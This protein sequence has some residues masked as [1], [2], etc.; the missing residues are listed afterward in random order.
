MK[1]LLQQFPK[2]V[3]GLKIL[4]LIGLVGLYLH[5]ASLQNHLVNTDP[6]Q[7]DQLAYLRFAKTLRETNYNYL[8]PRNQMPV[9]PLIQSLIYRPGMTEEEFFVVGKDF[10]I[11]LSLLILAALYWL[12][13]KNFPPLMTLNMM[14]ITGF[15]VFMFKAPFFQAELIFYLLNLTGFLLLLRMCRKPTIQTGLITGLVF[16][17]AHMTK[18]SVIPGLALFLVVMA[19]QILFDFLFHRA[20]YHKLLRKKGVPIILLLV[21]FLVSVSGYIINSKQ[22]YGHYFYNVNSTFYIWY[23]S[24]SEAKAGT[25][26]NGDRLGWPDLPA[27]EIPSPSK[28]LQEHTLSQILKRLQDGLIRVISNSVL[29]YGYAIYLFVYS[30]LLFTFSLL[31][32]RLAIAKIRQHFWL[33]LFIAAYFIFYLLAVAWYTPIAKGNRFILAYF[34]PYMFVLFYV[35]RSTER[36]FGLQALKLLKIINLL[37]LCT[38]AG[39]IYYIMTKTIATFYGGL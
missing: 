19:A 39:H 35:L 20:T 30:I 25:I 8:M 3:Q 9:Y 37:V 18:A 22:V 14:L 24:W 34:L 28:Y 2:Q 13:K 38:L 23:D 10:N 17:I 31:N 36:Y 27:E 11:F 32:W 21:I 26:A 16:G 33:I 15:T 4:L 1:E 5:G 12:F 7:T 6:L 29:S